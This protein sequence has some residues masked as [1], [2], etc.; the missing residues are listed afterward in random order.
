M[1]LRDYRADLHI[2]TCLSPCAELTMSPLAIAEAAHSR[3]IDLI[4]V[5]DHNSA[6]NVPAVSEA[7]ERFAIRVLP[8]IEITSREEI[9]ILALFDSIES[10]N[11]LQRILYEHLPG[12][13][14]PDTFGLQ[15]VVNAE[16]EVLRFN[17]RLLIGAVTLDIDSLVAAIHEFDGLAVA[18]H[19]DRESFSLISQLGFIPPELELDAVE[20]SSRTPLSAAC[21][22]YGIKL[23]ITTASDAH[24][25]EEI[26][27]A[28]TTFRLGDRTA[29]EIK[30]AF[31][32]KDGRRIL[33]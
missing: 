18:A 26:G 20:V 21:S 13:N 16:G 33:H 28:L 9:H 23:P 10:A 19:I 25:P 27:A 2:H 17:E 6:E 22:R 24:R 4:A 5:C 11:R 30:L 8:G 3:K 29:R 32:K 14:D 1:T 15:V 12:K 7:A 31:E